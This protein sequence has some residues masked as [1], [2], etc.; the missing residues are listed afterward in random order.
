MREGWERVALDRLLRQISRPV[1]VADITEVPFAG[2]RWYAEG[3]YARDV[4]LAREVKTKTL[5]LLEAGDVTYNRMWAT[6]ASFGRVGTHVAG[7][8]VTNDFPVF[9]VDTT[10]VLGEYVD[11]I[12]KTAAFQREASSRATGTTERKRLKEPEFLAI[13]VNLPPLAE[14]R[15]I[16]DLIGAVDEAIE[17]ASAADEAADELLREVRDR[18]FSRYPAKSI[19][20]LIDSISGGRSPSAV[21][22]PPNADQFGVL[23]ISA[24]GRLGFQPKES[25]TV[26]APGIFA[27]SM[28]VGKGDILITRANTA[29]RVG[30]VCRVDGNYPNLFL[31]DKTLRLTPSAEVDPDCL[32]AA[33]QTG[34]ARRQLSAAGSGTSASMKNISQGNIRNLKVGWPN[35]LSEQRNL[36][37]LIAR[38]AEARDDATNLADALRVLRTDLLTTLLS[39]AHEIPASYDRFLEASAA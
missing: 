13:M 19:E 29:E 28:R 21:D 38:L 11:L 4:V 10:R 14:Q 1:N 9:A 5:N 20:V 24:V 16:V 15:R 6:K 33:L 18:E 22:S 32:V 36:V 30:M 39:G 8:L 2:V 26:T 17:A 25:K 37:S 7:C 35:E 34:E 23:K 31:S 3:V 12:F 27:D